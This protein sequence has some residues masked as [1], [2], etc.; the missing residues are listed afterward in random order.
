MVYGQTA[1]NEVAEKVNL[2]K[3]RGKKLTILGFFFQFSS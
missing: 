2:H 3:N 1:L